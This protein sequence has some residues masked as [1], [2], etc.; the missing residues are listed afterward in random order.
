MPRCEQLRQND[1]G[2][3]ISESSAVFAPCEA[4]AAPGTA[5]RVNSR[6]HFG[7]VAAAEFSLE[8]QKRKRPEKEIGEKEGKMKGGRQKARSIKER[9]LVI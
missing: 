5:R 1:G 6:K 3:S 9:L 7:C 8:T 4:T 2:A